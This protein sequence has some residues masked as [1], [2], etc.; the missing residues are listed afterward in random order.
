[1]FDLPPR[2]PQGFDRDQH[3]AG[4]RKLMDLLDLMKPESKKNKTNQHQNLSVNED[5]EQVSAKPFESEAVNVDDDTFNENISIKLN[6][7]LVNE[8]VGH[9]T[10]DR[11]IT[12]ANQEL[13]S[14]IF[15]KPTTQITS[16]QQTKQFTTAPPTIQATS[17]NPTM[18]V[19]AGQVTTQ[20]TEGQPS[21]QTTTGQPTIQTTAGQP[22]TQVTA[23]QVTTA[24]SQ[25]TTTLPT[26]LVSTNK[27]IPSTD[28]R[29]QFQLK[30][31]QNTVKD[32]RRTRNRYKQRY[33]SKVK[34]YESLNQYF[35]EKEK[36]KEEKV[37]ELQETEKTEDVKSS[38]ELLQLESSDAKSDQ[39]QSHKSNFQHKELLKGR[40][41]LEILYY[42]D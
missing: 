39:T 29:V 24:Q 17:G 11:V 23:G 13:D 35:N 40:F 21:T 19:T 12:S 34:S 20:V 8:N 41:M 7:K 9:T 32:R 4:I 33:G 25:V 2:I 1:M 37:A 27:N 28:Y 30:R 3:F 10:T 5:N 15:A 38:E 36:I 16:G 18:Q 6:D 26:I 31:R 42:F 14:T 22:T